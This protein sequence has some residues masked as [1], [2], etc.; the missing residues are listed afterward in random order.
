MTPADTRRDKNFDE[1]I[2]YLEPGYIYIGS[3]KSAVQT[4]L[5]NCVSVCLWDDKLRYGGMNHFLYPFTNKKESATAVF[6]NIATKILI[7]KMMAAGS[8]AENLSAQIIGGAKKEEESDSNL[9]RDNVDVARKILQKKG[10]KIKSEDI[11]GHL[12]RKVVFDVKNGHL[13]VIKVH[14]IRA[15]DWVDYSLMEKEPEQKGKKDDR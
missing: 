14:Q 13:M 5:G 11:G 1:E 10:I 12:G 15:G 8:K 9:G 7:K 3:E 6:G 4:V 2:Y